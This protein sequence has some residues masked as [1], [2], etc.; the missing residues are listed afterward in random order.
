MESVS[1]HGWFA[2]EFT[3]ESKSQSFLL[4]LFSFMCPVVNSVNLSSESGQSQCGHFYCFG[5]FGGNDELNM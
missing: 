4:Y 5:K 1:L 2:V 3:T